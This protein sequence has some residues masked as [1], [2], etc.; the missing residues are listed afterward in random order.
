[1]AVVFAQLEIDGK[2]EGVHAFVVPIRI[3]GE[4]A[5]GVRIEDSGLK[6][7]L[8]GV[9]NG[10]LWFDGV[11]IPRTSL[12]NRFADVTP[13]G[14]YES[15]IESPGRRFFTMLGT[16]VLGRVCIGA[17]GNSAAK[18]ALTI[19]IKYADRRRQFESADGEPEARKSVGLGKRV[20]VRVALC[21]RR[22]LKQKTS[23]TTPRCI[24]DN[25]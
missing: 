15:P 9:D 25:K 14:V 1:M 13:E 6:M 8:N 11:R 23:S 7:G 21:G 5:P 4:P 16:L 18:M 12:L 3:D 20:S 2:S 19:A 17:A 24:R 22:I 10:R